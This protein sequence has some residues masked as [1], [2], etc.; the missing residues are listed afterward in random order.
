MNS[1]VPAKGRMEYE[2]AA[3]FIEASRRERF[4]IGGVHVGLHN[5]NLKIQ[6][7][8]T[9]F[10]TPFRTQLPLDIE[11]TLEHRKKLPLPPAG[12]K[13]LFD[14][15]THWQLFETE[16]FFWMKLFETHDQSHNRTAQMTKDLKKVILSVNHKSWLLDRI[17]RPFLEILLVNYLSTRQGLLLHGACVRDGKHA[18]IFSGE[19]GAGKTTMSQFWAF[20][21]GDISVLGDERLIVRR[22]KDG[23]F[24]YGTP[25]PGL[26]FIVSNERVPISNVFLIRHGQKHEVIPNPKPLLFQK[27][28]SQTFSSFWDAGQLNAISD[29]CAKLVSEVPCYELASLKDVSITD[30]VRDF[31]SR[32]D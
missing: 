25:W 30:F 26:G 28:F 4:R 5:D 23:W 13:L 22:E 14:G 6:D 19:S 12:A 11:I 17:L 32:N 2:D 1:A 27:I 15:N 7:W 16:D 10:Y 8:P 21:E 24:A 18:Y 29:T 20:K 31:A 9:P 3:I